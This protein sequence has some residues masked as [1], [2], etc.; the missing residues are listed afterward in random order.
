MGYTESSSL[1]IV[2]GHTLKP[3]RAGEFANPT[4]AAP[5]SMPWVRRF[6]IQYN[7]TTKMCLVFRVVTLAPK[8]PPCPACSR[9]RQCLTFLSGEYVASP[10]CL[11]L[12]FTEPRNNRVLLCKSFPEKLRFI[13]SSRELCERASKR[14]FEHSSSQSRITVQQFV[15]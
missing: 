9:F 14:R 2:N 3:C 4:T 12:C 7:H 1:Q 10:Q 6:Y 5:D 8:L 11:H 15:V 13:A